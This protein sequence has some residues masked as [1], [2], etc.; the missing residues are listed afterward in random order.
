MG[1]PCQ[2]WIAGRHGRVCARGKAPVGRPQA[3]VEGRDVLAPNLDRLFLAYFACMGDYVRHG[4]KGVILLGFS[5][6][7]SQLHRLGA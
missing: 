7:R 2:V 6:L 4:Q 5:G 1:I 3:Y